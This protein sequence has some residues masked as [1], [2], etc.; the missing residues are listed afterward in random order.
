MT[1]NLP[2][3]RWL[4]AHPAFRAGE[5][6]TA[7]LDRVPAALGSAARR[8]RRPLAGPFRLNLPRR[9]PP[10]PAPD[11]DAPRPTRRTP[12]ATRRAAS[13]RRCRGR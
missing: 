4:V 6:T 8:S 3:L 10:P 11:L 5:T 12:A 2:F 1:T 13:R 7:F 9:R